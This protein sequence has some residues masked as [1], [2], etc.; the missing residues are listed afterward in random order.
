MKDLSNVAG[1]DQVD[2]IIGL[3]ALH[4]GGQVFQT[5]WKGCLIKGERPFPPLA[6]LCIVL[7]VTPGM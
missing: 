6:I 5:C 2:I 1:L 3:V 7:S 4:Y